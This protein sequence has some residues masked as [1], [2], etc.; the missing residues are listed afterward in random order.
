MS[1]IPF[2]FTTLK[3]TKNLEVK[4][5]DWI[6]QGKWKKYSWGKFKSLMRNLACRFMSWLIKV[7]MKE[8]IALY[9]PILYYLTLNFLFNLKWQENNIWMIYLEL[10]DS[11]HVEPTQ[12]RKPYEVQSLIVQKKY[13]RPCFW[14]A[15][16]YFSASAIHSIA[17]SGLRVQDPGHPGHR[18]KPG[19]WFRIRT[20]RIIGSNPGPSEL[21]GPPG[22]RTNPPAGLY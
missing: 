4:K 18:F 13:F 5:N 9:T 11:G 10:G 8:I 21:T 20:V 22:P 1:P 16:Q 14:K 3:V 12:P 7:H 15:D 2:Q 17:A 19:C 6:F